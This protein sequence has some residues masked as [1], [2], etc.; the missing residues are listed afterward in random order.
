MVHF[1]ADQ[2][3]SHGR[4]IEYSERPFATIRE[5]DEALIENWNSVVQPADIVYHL[6]DFTLD[7]PITACQIL[8]RLNGHIKFIPGG[9][10]HWM[11]GPFDF[12]EPKSKVRGL[13]PT[14]EFLEPLVTVHF[15]RNAYALGLPAA[16]ICMCHY[17]M[18]QWDRSHYGAWHLHGHSHGTMGC[19]TGEKSLDIGVDCRDF[20]PVSLAELHEL[21]A[22][23]YRL[24]PSQFGNLKR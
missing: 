18:R 16:T 19:R 4:I 23:E 13:P 3:F 5:M 17:P 24:P 7:S 11:E 1:T 20:R 22:D 14:V 10:D 2:H 9:H 15:K 12:Q 8:W 21:F 6:G